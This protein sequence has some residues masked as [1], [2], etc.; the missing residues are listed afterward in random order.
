V[1]G[2]RELTLA[3]RPQRTTPHPLE[4]LGRFVTPDFV[5]HNPPPGA[6]AGTADGVAQAIATLKQVFPDLTLTI[7]DMV[8]EGDRV[9]VRATW[10]GTQRAAFMGVPASGKAMA[11]GSVHIF[12]LADCKLAEHWAEQDALGMLQQLGGMPAP[13]EATG[14]RHDRTRTAIGCARGTASTRAHRG[15]LKAKEALRCSSMK[16]RRWSRLATQPPSL[17]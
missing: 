10:R 1:K 2:R 17:S 12:R 5:D 9:A 16:P 8:A 15:V 13:A 4:A 6:T 3:P 7:D 11:M 14:S